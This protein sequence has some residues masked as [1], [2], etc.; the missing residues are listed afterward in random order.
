MDTEV[1]AALIDLH[2]WQNDHQK[3]HIDLARY[4]GAVDANYRAIQLALV[5]LTTSNGKI[6]DE[7]ATLKG[8]FLAEPARRKADIERHVDECPFR[9][10]VHA[11]V[12]EDTQTRFRVQQRRD[13][14]YADTAVPRRGSRVVKFS[15]F[16]GIGTLL[17]AAIYKIVELCK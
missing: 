14:D 3:D 5:D 13:E 9:E 15:V 6:L 1:H 12:T 10:G 4:L 17:G 8:Q 2:R 16:G 7:L 11:A